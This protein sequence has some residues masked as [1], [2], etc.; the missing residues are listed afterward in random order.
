MLDAINIKEKYKI[1]SSPTSEVEHRTAHQADHAVLNLYE[2]SRYAYNF[3]L[4]FD[5]PAVVA[6]IQGK[7]IMNLRSEA[8]F[9]FLPGQ[10]IVMPA[11]EL[12]YIDFPEATI[13]S[14]T[15]CLALEI[16]EGFLRETMVWLNEY[17]PRVDD[18]SWNWSKDNF[19]LLNNKL[20]Q[21]NLNSLIRVMVDNDFGKQMKASNTTRELIAS[22]MQTQAR[23]YLLHNLD[24]LSTRNRLAHV[25][26][27]IR[28]H[29][30]QPLHVNHLANQ[31][32]LSRAQFFRAFQREL[33]ETP[34][35][36]INRERLERA[37]KELLWKG[38]NITQACYESGFSSVNYF[39]RVFRQFEG[40][41]P[42][43]WIEQKG[44]GK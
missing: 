17:F 18:S 23:H 3:D 33:G 6:M 41:T 26:K 5:N 42:T 30:E 31:A 14:P 1:F 7:K 22:L 8:P 20:V 34:V 25:V 13:A 2:T 38:K 43:A 29:L 19:T 9:E 39:S 28:Q 11:S 24:K 4:Q 16:S 40:M 21:Q 36:F 27:Y 44:R 32:C 10:S 15:Q 12:M 37:K 35:R